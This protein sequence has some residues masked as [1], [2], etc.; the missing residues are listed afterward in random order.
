MKYTQIFWNCA[1]KVSPIKFRRQV[2]FSFINIAN[3]FVYFEK[4][5][6]TQSIVNFP[7]YDLNTKIII[8]KIWLPDF[9]NSAIKGEILRALIIVKYLFRTS[10]WVKICPKSRIW[11]DSSRFVTKK[12]KRRKKRQTFV[13]AKL[14]WIFKLSFLRN[15]RVNFNSLSLIFK[16]I[17]GTGVS[18]DAEWKSFGNTFSVSLSPYSH[19]SCAGVVLFRQPFAP[20]APKPDFATYYTRFRFFF[21][22]ICS[23]F[24]Q[25]W[26]SFQRDFRELIPKL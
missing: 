1:S 6:I 7:C 24:V 8:L 11:T 9:P 12:E 23:F 4:N 16:V 15:R 26:D 10:N 21:W 14:Q 20:L 18:G 19:K 25:L 17:P 5:G 13:V 22:F 3:N 2:H